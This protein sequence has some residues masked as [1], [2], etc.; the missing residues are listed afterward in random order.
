MTLPYSA[1][2]AVALLA[3]FAGTTDAQPRDR[4]AEFDTSFIAFEDEY[5]AVYSA[6]RTGN[7]VYGSARIYSRAVPLRGVQRERLSPENFYLIVGRADLA[8]A[9]NRRSRKRKIL[10]IGGTLTAVG[11]AVLLGAAGVTEMEGSSEDAAKL[12]IAGTT[13]FLLG[14]VVA[15]VGIMTYPHPVG[16]SEQRLMAYEYNRRLRKQLRLPGGTSVVPF[17]TTD[18]GGVLA[19]GRF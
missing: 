1:A 14:G 4:Q 8:D 19:V 15:Y 3:A 18:G 2:I 9:Y 5:S 10:M 12:A 16:E 13:A 7:Y 6:T 17:A 11:G